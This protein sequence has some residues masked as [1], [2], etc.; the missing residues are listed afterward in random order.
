VSKEEEYLMALLSDEEV[1]LP[2]ATT[3][4]EM[5]LRAM[6]TPEIEEG[7]PEPY[8]KKVEML[9]AI[10]AKI[11][12]GGFGGG[13][14][15]PVEPEGTLTTLTNPANLQLF[16]GIVPGGTSSC[17]A[18]PF[19]HTL[20][21][22]N[23]YIRS[24][25]FFLQSRN[26]AKL[27]IQ[28]VPDLNNNPNIDVVLYT[29]ELFSVS[30]DNVSSKYTVIAPKDIPIV[31]GAKYWVIINSNILSPVS[32]TTEVRKSDSGLQM[33]YGNGTD[34]WTLHSSKFAYEIV[35]VTK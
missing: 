23:N 1:E 2:E 5:Y 15:A 14:E 13:G 35:F 27:K 6:A 31:D 18:Q 33:K 12:T 17:I 10:L 8:T 3:I 21:G 7:L 20:T 24:I 4:E 22:G 11:D 26:P 25:S 29:S 16:T 30:A 32:A 9:K 19:L 34:V 28:L